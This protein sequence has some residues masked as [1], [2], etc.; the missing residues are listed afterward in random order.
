MYRVVG[1]D[2]KQSNKLLMSKRPRSFACRLPA[3][4]AACLQAFNAIKSADRATFISLLSS[5]PSHWDY[6]LPEHMQVLSDKS[7]RQ[8]II[9]KL[10]AMGDLEAL[11]LLF[12]LT[13][14][15]VDA[16]DEEGVTALA[17]AVLGAGGLP[18]VQMLV[19]KGAAIDIASNSGAV[20]L[21]SVCLAGAP[22]VLRWVLE[23]YQIS[24][25]DLDL[26]TLTGFSPLM[27]TLDDRNRQTLKGRLECVQILL[28]HG[29]NVNQQDLDG[30]TVVHWAA[31]N[32]Q[33]DILK[34]LVLENKN[35]PPDLY[36]KNH[37]K[38]TPF[39]V[40]LDLPDN[41][42]NYKIIDVLAT[43]LCLHS[44]GSKLKKYYKSKIRDQSLLLKL[45]SS[46]DKSDSVESMS[47][48][49]A[50]ESDPNSIDNMEP[51]KYQ[52]KI[53]SSLS[54][55]SEAHNESET[56]FQGED[57]KV[58]EHTEIEV[59]VAKRPRLSS[60]HDSN[61][62]ELRGE[63][64]A[65][66]LFPAKIKKE[67]ANVLADSIM[68]NKDLNQV[69]FE[70]IEKAD[71]TTVK[72]ICQDKLN[73]LTA[74][75]YSEDEQVQMPPLS[76]ALYLGHL[77][78]AELLIKHGANILQ[79]D[80]QEANCMHRLFDDKTSDN[81][82]YI[83]LTSL[84][85]YPSQIIKKQILEALE[86]QD[87]GGRTP[88]V[89]SVCH[90][91]YSCTSFLLGILKNPLKLDCNGNTPFTWAAFKGYP[92]M[93]EVFV[94]FYQ[95]SHVVDDGR[96]SAAH[97]RQ[98]KK[99]KRIA[100][101]LNHTNYPYGNTAIHYAAYKSHSSKRYIECIQLLLES[102]ARFDILNSKR[103]LPCDLVHSS[104]IKLKSILT[105]DNELVTRKPEMFKSEFDNPSFLIFADGDL[106]CGKEKYCI[107]WIN[108]VDSASPSP[109]VYITQVVSGK[110][111]QLPG[112]ATSFGNCLCGW[113]G[114]CLSESK[115]H[116]CHCLLLNEEQQ[117]SLEKFPI[118]IT[119]RYSHRQF[120][121]SPEALMS[122]IRIYECNEACTCSIHDCPNRLVQ[123][124]LQF[125]LEVFRIDKGWS[126]RT[127]EDICQGSFVIEYLGEVIT[128]EEAKVRLS[129]RN[130]DE[131]FIWN[132]NSAQKIPAQRI[133]SNAQSD[134]QRY[135]IDPSSYGNVARFLSHCCD[136][137]LVA[138][139]VYV[140]H[141]D[142]RFPRIALFAVRDISAGEE[143]T[144][145]YGYAEQ[146][147]P[148]RC[149]KCECGA[150][151]CRITLL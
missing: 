14:A 143:L 37:F 96:T 46:E 104:D 23:T 94:N 44:K 103:Q 21:H 65:E 76:F 13:D 4:P 7:I 115:S 51:S 111:V 119:Q 10:A 116:R 75:S 11:N 18:V 122:N 120:I 72:S 47:Y 50:E 70:A 45:E 124:G 118:Y 2:R 137:N 123:R 110:N 88:I 35:N 54:I 125:R 55:S 61:L 29:A 63:Q 68:E 114:G 108:Q 100:F 127:L 128:E 43:A 48:V 121:L 142:L 52:L 3:A 107:R 32:L 67:F 147:I 145:D 69:L 57:I 38:Q 8:P 92:K 93:L 79:K 71:A 112:P 17:Y 26:P 86:D 97:R 16:P 87:I 109:F 134:S 41:P 12:S 99:S 138:K 131:T 62:E 101:D 140:Q 136:P 59:S 15:K 28:A 5:H 83:C 133:L 64:Q 39:A 25:E 144:F 105:P 132:L 129:S 77:E 22:E 27:Y 49:E 95:I 58:E 102:G 148:G 56:N 150:L 91:K 141:R 53:A 20:L 106:A 151:E 19:E 146:V 74:C 60:E 24:G 34:F 6:L 81:N 78:I 85:E 36:I 90:R 40:A 126:V 66:F 1:D 73:C 117:T 42:E 84:L 30:N 80:R 149:L 9:H 130:D 113:N 31:F 82:A 98:R 135:A 89:Y 33:V 139:E